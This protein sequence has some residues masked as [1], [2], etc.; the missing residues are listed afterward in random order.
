MPIRQIPPSDIVFL[1]HFTGGGIDSVLDLMVD[2][3]FS[4][5]ES[6]VDIYEKEITTPRRVVLYGIEKR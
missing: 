3:Y 6:A 1:A 2:D 5:L 4:Y